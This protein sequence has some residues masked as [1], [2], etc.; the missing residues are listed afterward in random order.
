M[1]LREIL[2][3]VEYIDEI[4]IDIGDG[5]HEIKAPDA[6]LLFFLKDSLLGQEVKTIGIKDNKLTMWCEGYRD[7][8]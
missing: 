6:E 3:Q 5:H 2:M 4:T 8:S 7:E 1:T